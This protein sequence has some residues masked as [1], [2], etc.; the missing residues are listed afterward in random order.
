[1]MEMVMSEAVLAT[2]IRA[3]DMARGVIALN[4][5]PD[6]LRADRNHRVMCLVD[7]FLDDAL[8]REAIHL[9]LNVDWRL[10][11]AIALAAKPEFMIWNLPTS[12]DQVFSISIGI[13][14]AIALQPI[15][16]VK[17]EPEFELWGLLVRLGMPIE[18]VRQPIEDLKGIP[19][20]RVWNSLKAAWLQAER[21]D[22]E[23]LE[24][25]DSA[26]MALEAWCR[27]PDRGQKKGRRA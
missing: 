15:R 6:S 22:L 1:M 5:L 16:L 20:T 21:P 27:D 17:S 8:G 10:D 18:S 7:N 19:P 23:R 14:T 12:R 11:A 13:L 24:A 4:H 9:A 2:E 26:L 25:W 3:A